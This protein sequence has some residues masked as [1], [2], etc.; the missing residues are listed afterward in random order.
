M[1]DQDNNFYLISLKILIICLLNNVKHLKEKFHVDHFWEL[2]GY[3]TVTWKAPTM[4]L[5]LVMCICMLFSWHLYQNSRICGFQSIW[6]TFQ[7]FTLRLITQRWPFKIHVS[8]LPRVVH[9]NN[10]E[11]HHPCLSVDLHKE[12]QE[13]RNFLFESKSLRLSHYLTILTTL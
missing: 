8:L 13:K 2:K 4:P 3:R 5:G 1:F 7:F 10:S 6:S 9:L 12:L 11:H